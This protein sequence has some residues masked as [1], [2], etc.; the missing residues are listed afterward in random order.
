M[1]RQLELPN[2]VATELAG[3]GDAV[4][5]TDLNGNVT[6]LNSV[7]ESLTG[8]STADAAG[9]NLEE[10]FCIVNE[11]TRRPVENPAMRALRERIACEHGTIRIRRGIVVSGIGIHLRERVDSRRQHVAQAILV[12]HEP[13][14]CRHTFTR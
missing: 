5:T 7:A 12:L 10:V 13:V 11:A 14:A 2:E 1:R 9:K 3:P 8:W 6:Y 4:I